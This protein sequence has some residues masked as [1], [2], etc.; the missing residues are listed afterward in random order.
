MA[1]RLGPSSGHRLPTGKPGSLTEA[2]TTDVWSGSKRR[3]LTA[4]TS[5]IRATSSATAEKSADGSAPLATS[6]A[7]RRSEAC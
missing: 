6:V 7:T 2:T 3:T 4:E 5:R 1:L